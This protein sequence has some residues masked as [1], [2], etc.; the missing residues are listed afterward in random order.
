[1]IGFDKADIRRIKAQETRARG[2][3]TI[4]ELLGAENGNITE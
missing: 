3:S 2:I 1:M 4:G